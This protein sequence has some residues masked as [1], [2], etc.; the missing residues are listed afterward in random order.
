MAQCLDLKTGRTVWEERLRGTGAKNSSWSS[1]VLAGDRLYVPNP[2]A[3]VF[4]LSASP[5]FERLATNPLGG[6]PMNASL[7]V[8]DGAIFIRTDRHLWCVADEEAR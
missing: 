7:A 2:N 8:A 6:E 3:D 5:S 4:V 1:F